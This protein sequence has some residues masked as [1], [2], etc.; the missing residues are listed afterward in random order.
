L[1]NQRDRRTLLDTHA[2]L[3]AISGDARLSPRAAEV[4]IGPS[5]L[6]LSAASI[7]EMLIKTSSGKLTLPKPA[8][9]YLIKKMAENRVELAP[10]TL[11][12]ILQ[13]E[14]L[15]IYHRDPFDRVLIAQ[16]LAEG[17]PI[18]TSDAVFRKYPVQVIW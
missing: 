2:F 4:F 9:P 16:S 14:R 18:V 1:K 10:I 17:W 6:Y 15:P 5:E 7:W 3:W 8:G 12:H 11:D 13:I